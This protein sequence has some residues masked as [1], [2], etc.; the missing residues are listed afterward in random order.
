MSILLAGLVFLLSFQAVHSLSLS[1]SRSESKVY[2]FPLVRM[3]P[4]SSGIH[5]QIVCHSI[6]K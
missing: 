4:R 6:P 1:I 2:T 3:E 5:P